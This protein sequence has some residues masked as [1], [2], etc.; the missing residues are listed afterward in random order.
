MLMS[1][2]KLYVDYHDTSD[3]F[4]VRQTL[5]WAPV[6]EK[7]RVTFCMCRG[8]PLARIATV[9]RGLFT[10]PAVDTPHS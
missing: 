2:G 8:S 10:I 1:I 3:E 9:V 5:H 4:L 7:P 6:I